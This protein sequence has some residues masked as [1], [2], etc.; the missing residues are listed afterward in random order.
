MFINGLALFSSFGR[1]SWLFIKKVR[2]GGNLRM[3]RFKQQLSEVAETPIGSFPAV[4]IFCPLKGP[5]APQPVNFSWHYR[6]KILDMLG[7]DIGRSTVVMESAYS[8]YLLDTNTNVRA[9]DGGSGLGQFI[10]C[11][12]GME[13]SNAFT[14]A[15]EDRSAIS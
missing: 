8:N 14:P 15:I 1:T 12:R 11:N 4:N 3:H 5:A 7:R 9:V 2:Y 10:F 13:I 6:G